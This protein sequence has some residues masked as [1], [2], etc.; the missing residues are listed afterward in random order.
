MLVHIVPTVPPAVNGLADYCFRLWEFWPQPRPDWTC[1]APKFP[2]DAARLWPEA[3][4]RPFEL[5]GT[6]LYEAL[7]QLGPG[8]V[9]LH[10]VGYA[11][12]SK[13]CPVWLP[14]ALRRWKRKH[15]SKARLIVMFHELYAK[16]SIRKSS[17][18]LSPIARNIASQLAQ[19]SDS[20]C[21]SCARYANLLQTELKAVPAKGLVLPVGA[22]ILPSGN[23]DFRKSWP[24]EHG[25]RLKAVIFGLPQTRIWT[26]IAHKALL[27]HMIQNDLLESITMLGLAP[28]HPKLL[29]EE[30]ELRAWIGGGAVWR[31]SFGLP[32]GAISQFLLTQDVGLVANELDILSK[33]GVYAALT[34]H[35]VVTIAKQD[36]GTNST[37]LSG[38][39]YPALLN[40]DSEPQVLASLLADPG[41]I[42]RMRHDIE[43]AALETLSWHA[44]SSAWSALAGT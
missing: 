34:V 3:H 8:T 17:F 42:Q 28:E 40:L 24:L 30:A 29:S 32:T 15:G 14:A 6:G 39:P 38:Q 11:Y 9:V 41:E 31:E 5:S 36:A 13:G 21:T 37:P 4:L 19:L 43:S 27:R 25:A 20:W 22:N 26:L 18:W 33:S 12:H 2:D 10:Y 35:G 1:L 44:I 7:D 23:V 16:G